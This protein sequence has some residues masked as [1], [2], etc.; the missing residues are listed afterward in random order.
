NPAMCSMVDLPL[1]DWPTRATISP[2]CR[3]SDTPRNTSSRRSPCTKVRLM[4]RNASG[5][6]MAQSLDRLDPG[7]APGPISRGTARQQD[8]NH[9]H[10]YD[11]ARAHLHRCGGY[12]LD[13]AP[14]RARA[15]R[16]STIASRRA[17]DS[18][19]AQISRPRAAPIAV[20]TRPTAAADRKKARTIV[21]G[22]AP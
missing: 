19:L 21:P 18:M 9:D 11:L 16:P 4:S 20:P 8:G 22:E 12:K 7:A 5:L 13:L 1:P 15:A 2:A 10:R 3:S 17:T 6:L 14:A